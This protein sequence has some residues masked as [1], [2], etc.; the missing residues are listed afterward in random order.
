VF[1][2]SVLATKPYLS[3]T[4][5]KQENIIL[6]MTIWEMLIFKMSSLKMSSFFFE[7]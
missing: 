5:A 2:F 3:S 7:M 1:G 4:Q 6:E